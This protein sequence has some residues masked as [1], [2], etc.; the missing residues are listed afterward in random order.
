MAAAER[1]GAASSAFAIPQDQAGLAPLT[2]AEL[3]GFAADDHLTAFRVFAEHAR[4]IVED[5]PPLRAARAPS[6]A[7]RAVCRA[8]LACPVETK[9]AARHFFE[10]SFQPF[11]V[12]PAKASRGFVTGYYEPIVGGSLTRSAT[13]TAPIL[14]RPDDLVSLPP[15]VGL[16]GHPELNAARR[17]RDGGLAPFPDRAAIEDGALAGRYTVLVWLADPVEVFLVQ[18]QGSARVVLPDGRQIRLVYA[19]RNGHSYTSIGPILIESGEIAPSDMGLAA[20]K[21][22][23]RAH[24]QGAGEAGAALMLRNK[25]YVF[26]ALSAD[27]GQMEG[28]I[29]GAGVSLSP[30]RS[31]AVDRSIW[32]YGLPFWLSGDLPWRSERVVAFRRLMMAGDTGS[33]IVGSARADIFFGSGA[34]A[35]ALA[36]GIRHACDV[37]VLLP[38]SE[39]GRRG[40]S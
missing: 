33:A 38:R 27:L 17:T 13:F 14:A 37:V 23:I 30:L 10:T 21:G 39:D 1:P 36:G 15:G 31:I 20:L 11:R 22:W 8:A 9:S 25:S 28:P 34:A 5:R 32:C 29:G 26:F 24:G 6:D 16:P 12:L 7:L 4:A 40:V 35:G 2:F 18:V 19:G 3:D